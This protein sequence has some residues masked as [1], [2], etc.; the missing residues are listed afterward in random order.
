MLHQI[1]LPTAGTEKTLTQVMPW[2]RKISATSPRS[3]SSSSAFRAL[4][5]LAEGLAGL[6]AGT[7]SAW[8][9]ATGRVANCPRPAGSWL[10]A[11]VPP[12]PDSVACLSSPRLL[13]EARSYPAQ[14]ALGLTPKGFRG[15]SP[16]E[17]GPVTERRCAAPCRGTDVLHQGVGLQGDVGPDDLMWCSWF[18]GEFEASAGSFAGSPSWRGA[19]CSPAAE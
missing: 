17:P 10:S 14:R 19:R 12:A 16:R 1:I 9:L 7:V 2:R 8:R 18:R 11:R 3:S 15:D 4:R 13:S 5:P 6:A